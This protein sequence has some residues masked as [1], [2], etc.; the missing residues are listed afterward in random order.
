MTIPM[1]MN[2]LSVSKIAIKLIRAYR[3][4]LSP[5][6]GQQCRF[7]PTCSCYGEEAIARFGLAKGG[8]LTLKRIA[9]CHPWHPGGFDYVPPADSD[10][11]EYLPSSTFPSLLGQQPNDQKTAAVK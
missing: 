9:K 2:P 6:M 7:Y 8:W 1:I 3:L 5:L 11:A 4:V 10:Q